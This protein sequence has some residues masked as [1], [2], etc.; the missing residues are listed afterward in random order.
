MAISS[1][2]IMPTLWESSADKVPSGM[3]ALAY[4]I[5]ALALADIVLSVLAF[6]AQLGLLV[7][8]SLGFAHAAISIEVRICRPT[9]SVY[10]GG[11]DCD[12]P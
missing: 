11:M 8:G 9:H 1:H 4:V 2:D 12:N 5:N 3:F 6:V 10:A 7:A